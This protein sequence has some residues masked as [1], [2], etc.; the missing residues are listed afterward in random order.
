MKKQ[1]IAVGDK[2]ENNSIKKKQKSHSQIIYMSNYLKSKK[3]PDLNIAKPAPIK[4]EQVKKD[5]LIILDQYRRE[6]E[7]KRVW[8]KQFQFYTKEALSVSGMTFLFMFMFNL[9]SSIPSNYQPGLVSRTQTTVASGSFES[10][11]NLKE[12]LGLETD[13]SRKTASQT[14]KIMLNSHKKWTKKLKNLNKKNIIFGEKPLSSDY[15]GF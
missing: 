14:N 12:S 8:K 15:K 5:N 9:M 2:Q 11:E 10:G 1:Q 13:S 7:E 4:K 6:K 3:I